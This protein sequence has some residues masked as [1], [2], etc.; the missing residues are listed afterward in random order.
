M[1]NGGEY[2]TLSRINN[3]ERIMASRKVYLIVKTRLI[4]D[5]EEG[6][7]V[8]GVMENMDYGF[9]PDPDQATLVDEEIR[10]WEIQDSK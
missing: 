3:G 5:I 7:S 9:C 2:D 8:S 10:D 4:L 6:E 1:T